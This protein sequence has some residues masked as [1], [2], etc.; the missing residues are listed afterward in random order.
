MNAFERRLFSELKEK[1]KYG[2]TERTF[3]GYLKLLRPI[4]GVKNLKS[5]TFLK[6]TDKVINYISSKELVSQRKYYSIILTILS[7][8]GKYKKLLDVYSKAHDEKK[9][10]LNEIPTDNKNDKQK[11]NWTSMEDLKK[12]TFTLEKEL[13]KNKNYDTAFKM[14]LIALYTLIEPRRAYDYIQM[15]IVDKYDAEKH[16][17][18][19]MNYLSVKTNEFIFNSYKT[20]KY[21]G[22]YRFSFKQN[23]D[24][25]RVLR[26]YLKYRNEIN[27]QPNYFLISPLTNKKLNESNGITMPLSRITKKY[28]GKNVSVNMIRNIYLS[29]NFSDSKKQL[30][31][32]TE[33]MGTSTKIANHTYI[34]TD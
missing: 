27:T 25:K 18:D 10:K 11:E 20:S 16:D 31:E 8:T 33:K 15:E 13:K 7:R 24:F 29:E 14:M 26:A 5:L 30:K 21:Y 19:K 2:L 22:L 17:D 6:D 3:L 32:T 12:I 34:K 9:T 28:I 4:A 23:K 1:S